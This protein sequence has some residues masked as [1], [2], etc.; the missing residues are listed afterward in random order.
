MSDG[1]ALCQVYVDV[2][3]GNQDAVPVDVVHGETCSQV[4]R[5]RVTEV[6]T[7]NGAR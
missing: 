1:Y 2:V 3:D 4:I 6:V 5:G 7:Y